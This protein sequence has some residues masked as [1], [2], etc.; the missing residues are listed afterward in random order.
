[1]IER[2]KVDRHGLGVSEKK[3]RAEKQQDRWHQDRPK[4][5]DMLQR[6]E[7]HPAKAI[8]NHVDAT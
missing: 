5:I 6:I 2:P 8:S 7:T 1:V 3:W 4:R